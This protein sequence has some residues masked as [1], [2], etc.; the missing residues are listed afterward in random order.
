MYRTLDLAHSLKHR[1]PSEHQRLWIT[2]ALHKT[3]EPKRERAE[4]TI[5]GS[6]VSSAPMCARNST[7]WLDQSSHSSHRL[8]QRDFCR[9]EVLEV[10]SW[11]DGFD[12]FSNSQHVC[13]WA[14]WFVQR[15]SQLHP[16]V[17]ILIG[18]F[19]SINLPRVASNKLDQHQC[20][21]VWITVVFWLLAV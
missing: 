9:P 16:A 12:N 8:R 2:T 10:I 15:V 11:V 19:R 17:I 6:T 13:E 5:R 4:L 21:S 14:C 1:T 7:R 20:K 18:L 3:L